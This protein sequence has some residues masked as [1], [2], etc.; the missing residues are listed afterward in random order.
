MDQRSASLLRPVE[1]KGHPT[2]PFAF[3][4][5][6]AALILDQPL[7]DRQPHAGGVSI[8]AQPEGLK[9]VEDSIVILR[10]DARTV[11]SH[12]E[13]DEIS[14]AL[15]RDMDMSVRFIMVLDGVVYE[16]P[17]HLLE[18][19]LVSHQRCQLR[20]HGNREALRR[21]QELDGVLHQ[22]SDIDLF[23]IPLIVTHSRVLKQVIQ[24][25][26]HPSDPLS[27]LAEM[28]P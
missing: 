19:N 6:R 11:V 23:D 3:H 28:F 26:L 12:G 17:E 2:F 22:A 16:I 18:R 8:G 15:G 4:P 7:H 14:P 9:L 13:F 1:S 20:P 25:L 21:I 5:D 27:H 24:K 10:C